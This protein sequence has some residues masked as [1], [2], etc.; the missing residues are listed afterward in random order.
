MKVLVIVPA[1]NEEESLPFLMPKLR[2]TGWDCLVVNDCSTDS[3]AE[4]L[5]S[6]HFNHIDLSNNI[7]IAGVTQ[8][9]FK[10]AAENHY[11]AAIVI[12]GD[13]QHP[14][15]YAKILIDKVEEGYDYV[16]GSRF[17]EKKKPWTMRMIGSRL[18]CL[19]IRIK[20]G[21]RVTDPTSG[22]RALGRKTIREFADHMN[23][24]AE[25]DAFAHVIHR[26]YRYV[27]VGVQMEEREAGTS[28]FHNPLKSIQFMFD[29][30]ISI[31]IFQ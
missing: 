23:F 3:T 7:G 31:L 16:V 20:T 12:D 26:K 19:A 27:E 25:P 14:L 22:M 11:D 29:V 17:L 8:M 4:L 30:L 21:K 18:I 9:G 15:S 1:F 5:D 10:Y 6:H 2:D 28:Y 24:V 13:G